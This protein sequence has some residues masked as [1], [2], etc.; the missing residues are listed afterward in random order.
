MEKRKKGKLG[1]FRTIIS[2]SILILLF[3]GSSVNFLAEKGLKIPF[4][5]SVSIHSVCPLGG[6]ES[7]YS[8]ATKGSFISK[9]HPSALVMLVLSL[10]ITLL[11]GSVFCGWI[12]PF[13]T[14]QELIGRIGKKLFP[15]TF[16]RVIPQKVDKILRFIRYPVLA[17][18]LYYTAVAGKLIFEGYDPFYAL[19]NIFSDEILTTAYLVLGVTVVLSLFIER[20]FCKY[21]CPYG[22]VVGVASKFSIFKLRRD[23]TSCVNC[24]LCD[25][26][27]PMNIEVSSLETV[28][29]HQCISC[30]KCTSGETCP[31]N[32]TVYISSS[33]PQITISKEAVLN[34]N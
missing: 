10:V 14:A 2:V 23:K 28:N 26:A 19:M 18:I 15:K 29:S 31:V 11:F 7:T 24:K 34:E 16:N 30:Y 8:L 1:L 20:P 25:K 33:N 32:Y 6:L 12:C 9:I 13:G 5:P 4:L 17:I 27:C 3:A 22:A 21:A